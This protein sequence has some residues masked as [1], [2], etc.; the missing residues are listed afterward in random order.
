MAYA[1]RRVRRGSYRRPARRTV[2]RYRRRTRVYRRGRRSSG[3]TT[4]RTIKLTLDGQWTTKTAGSGATFNPFYFAPNTLPGFMDYASTYSHFRIKKCLLTISRERSTTDGSVGLTD[5]YLIVGSRPFASLV[6]PQ[7]V[8]DQAPPP[9]TGMQPGLANSVPNFRAEYLVPPQT[10]NAL[11]QTRWQKILTPNNTRPYITVG[12]YP[13]TLV[14]TFGPSPGIGAALPP[15]SVSATAVTD[16]VVY[17][18][19]FEARRWMPFTWAGGAQASPAY[20]ISFFGP[21][22]VTD[23]SSPTQE[24]EIGTVVTVNVTLTVYCQFKGQK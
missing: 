16:A 8:Q 18:R 17:Q 10:E 14:G 4:S 9:G 19:I 22:M 24:G 13:Y 11:R 15:G 12:F 23:A 6:A 5:N 1:R 7:A 3:A 20:P 2:R 21:Y